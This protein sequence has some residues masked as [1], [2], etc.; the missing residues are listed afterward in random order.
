MKLS[1][2]YFHN[3]I[4]VNVHCNLRYTQYSHTHGGG[5][6]ELWIWFYWWCST[7]FCCVLLLFSFILVVVVVAVFFA[8]FMNCFVDNAR[9]CIIYFLCSIIFN[10]RV[11]CWTRISLDQP[12]YVSF[13]VRTH[14]ASSSSFSYFFFVTFEHNSN[15]IVNLYRVHDFH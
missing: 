8:I 15:I 9:P 3:S 14:S 11:Q 6:T 4:I 10:A 7:R 13:L 1:T 12:Q 2:K 5:L